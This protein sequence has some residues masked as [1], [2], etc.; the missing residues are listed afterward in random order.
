[1]QMRRDQL[2]AKRSKVWVARR[3]NTLSVEHRSPAMSCTPSRDPHVLGPLNG[4]AV[5]DHWLS[6]HDVQLRAP[7]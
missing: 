2:D 4:Q 6:H 1:M 3:K 5:D 7:A